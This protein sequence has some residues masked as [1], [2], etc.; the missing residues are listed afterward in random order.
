MSQYNIRQP[1][2]HIPYPGYRC[3]CQS[4]PLLLHLLLLLLLHT[5]CYH[6]LPFSSPQLAVT[7]G[8]ANLPRCFLV[9]AE[10]QCG[11]ASLK[12]HRYLTLCLHTSTFRSDKKCKKCG[13]ILEGGHGIFAPSRGRD[14]DR[15][16][17]T[18]PLRAIVVQPNE[19]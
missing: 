12:K 11:L 19:R 15:P 13:E 16:T 14:S 18:S 1:S 10:S 17:P 4:A 3:E 6:C 8:L 5:S 7:R 2:R 9:V